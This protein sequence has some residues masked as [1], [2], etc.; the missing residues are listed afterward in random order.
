MY[1]CT[2]ARAL[3]RMRG[4]VSRGEE[5][6]ELVSVSGIS[7]VPFKYYCYEVNKMTRGNGACVF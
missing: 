6:R 2:R 7:I 4:A 3:V 1:V 5:G